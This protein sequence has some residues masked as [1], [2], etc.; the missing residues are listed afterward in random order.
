[1]GLWFACQHDLYMQNLDH[2]HN[3]LRLQCRV[4]PLDPCWRPGHHVA[5]IEGRADVDDPTRL[6]TDAPNRRR[7][8][9]LR[10]RS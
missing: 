7:R 5:S 6:N 4:L 10:G 2:K 8:R 1:M 3:N 9:R